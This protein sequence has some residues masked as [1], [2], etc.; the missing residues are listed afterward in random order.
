MALQVSLPNLIDRESLGVVHVLL[1]HLVQGPFEPYRELVRLL[2]FEN[3]ADEL[4]EVAVLLVTLPMLRKEAIVARASVMRDPM[5]VFRVNVRNPPGIY[6][7]RLEY[8][9]FIEFIGFPANFEEELLDQVALVDGAAIYVV[10]A[11]GRLLSAMLHGS[12]DLFQLL[13]G[14]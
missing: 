9:G 8:S 6:D 14:K 12:Q 5:E 4:L 11:S 2:Q 1:P 7:G 3:L 10:E 13:K